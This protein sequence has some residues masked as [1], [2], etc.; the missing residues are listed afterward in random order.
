MLS[1]KKIKQI[2]VD[3]EQA[4]GEEPIMGRYNRFGLCAFIDRHPLM[5]KN[6]DETILKYQKEIL[7]NKFRKDDFTFCLNNGFNGLYRSQQA[8]WKYSELHHL[9]FERRDWC[10]RELKRRFNYEVEQ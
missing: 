5:V 7:G 2:L 9:K 6:K 8:C 4:F 3:A 10:R 1:Q